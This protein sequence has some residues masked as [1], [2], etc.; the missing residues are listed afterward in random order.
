MSGLAEA[1]A[2][3]LAG[4]DVSGARSV[5]VGSLACAEPVTVAV[6]EYERDERDERMHGSSRGSRT[7]RVVAC[8]EVRG[9]ALSIGAVC[10]AALR[11][12]GWGG[13]AGDGVERVCGLDVGAAELLGRDSSGRWLCAVEA[14]A[15]IE[16]SE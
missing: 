3:V 12:S 10:E 7:V 1:V 16:R 15:T 11:R 2:G 8:R 5:A 14:R 6:G 9:D 4:A 13:W